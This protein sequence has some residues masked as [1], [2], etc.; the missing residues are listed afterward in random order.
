LASLGEIPIRRS[1]R[2]LDVG[3]G[4]GQLLTCLHRAGFERLLGID[5]YITTDAEPEP[6]LHLRRKSLEEVQGKFDVIMFHH[7]LEH[8]MDQ[9]E[10]LVAARKLLDH[11]GKILLRLPSCESEAWKWYEGDWVQL[12]AP[13]HF[14]LHT[15]KS[16]AVA[17][18]R[19][20]LT[21]HRVW[22]DATFFQF[23]ASE[24]YRKGKALIDAQ[25]RPTNADDHF[26]AETLRTFERETERLNAL[27]RG[28]QIV[29][30]LSAA[31]S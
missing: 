24:H 30:L 28:D 13:R 18:S 31:A 27:G 6:G 4:S 8:I 23:W 10:T 3:C 15:R 16:L 2:I 29:A 14:Y 7:V 26:S 25:G 9:V 21:V 12:D 5:P 19:A 22:C 20:A 17:A 1:M 11:G